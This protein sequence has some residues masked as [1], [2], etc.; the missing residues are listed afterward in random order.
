MN[1]DPIL[2]IASKKMFIIGYF[3]LKYSG[4]VR[5]REIGTNIQC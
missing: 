1:S 5:I 3:P 2:G 4:L